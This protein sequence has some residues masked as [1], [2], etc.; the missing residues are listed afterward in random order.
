MLKLLTKGTPPPEPQRRDAFELKVWPPSVRGEGRGIYVAVLGLFVLL[1]FGM[2]G[3]YQVAN[4][5]LKL[6]L[7]VAEAPAASANADHVRS[8]QSAGK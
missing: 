7:F 6:T 2:I 5:D 8:G 4:A 1:I 3:V